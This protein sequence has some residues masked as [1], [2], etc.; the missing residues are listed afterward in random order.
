MKKIDKHNAQV[1][2]VNTGWSGGPYGVGK[3]MNLPYT[4]AMITAALNHELDKEEF[5]AHPVFGVLMPKN[6]PGVPSD[7]LNPRNTW[8][9]KE[10]Y[11]VQAKKLASLFV[12]NFQKFADMPENIKNAAPKAE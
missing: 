8:A 5:V 1:Y 6:C 10:A 11:D 12:K 4:R 3:R 7:I 9:D 2:L